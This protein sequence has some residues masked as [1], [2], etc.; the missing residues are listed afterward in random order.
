MLPVVRRLVGLLAKSRGGNDVVLID[1]HNLFFKL[2]GRRSTHGADLL[3]MAARVADCGLGA[4][5]VILVCDGNPPPGLLP[6]WAER[7]D[8]ECDLSFQFSG[9]DREADDVIE[10][11]LAAARRADGILIISADRRLRD[12]GKRHG[13]EVL[14]AEHFAK[15]L[16]G[17]DAKPASRPRGHSVP[18][19]RGEV[20]VWLAEFGLDR[21]GRPDIAATT[22]RTAEKKQSA[23]QR[24]GPRATK[25]TPRPTQDLS[26]REAV[27]GG[28]QADA[29]REAV[30]HDDPGMAEWLRLF[31]PRPEDLRQKEG[32]TLE[33]TPRARKAS[34]RGSDRRKGGRGGLEK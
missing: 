3:A 10:S 20:A 13:A 14:D 6:A 26:S 9:P 16:S 4:R 5:P 33:V 19:S 28:S 21:E 8:A 24:N 22:T 27:S 25:P 29:R 7:R 2:R 17:A 32:E 15:Q 12:F 31:P 34:S 11:L 18:L 30:A 1:A 23:R